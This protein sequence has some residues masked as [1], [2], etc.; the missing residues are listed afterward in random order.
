MKLDLIREQK[1]AE[2]VLTLALEAPLSFHMFS[3]EVIL[4]HIAC[5]IIGWGHSTIMRLSCVFSM[6]R[7]MQQ[8]KTRNC[9]STFER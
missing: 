3:S 6:F 4:H 5:I 2:M 7:D 1:R 8:G 9:L